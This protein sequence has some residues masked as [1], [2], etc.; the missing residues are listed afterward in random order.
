MYDHSSYMDGLGK[1]EIDQNS[2]LDMTDL[3]DKYLASFGLYSK[4]DL[5]EARYSRYSRF[6][7]VLDPYSRLNDT[8]EHLFF[9]KPDLHICATGTE[10]EDGYGGKE[11][12]SVN[13]LTLNPQ[14]DT[15][16]YFRDLI[17]RYPDVV[18]ELQN[19][20]GSNNK[21]PFSHLLSFT[22]NS[23]L[24]LPGSEAST[25]DTGNT[26]F[27]TNL[28]YLKDSEV[29]DENPSFSLEFI[30]TKKL[31]V[32]QYFKAY[33]MYH[34]ARKSGIVT[35]P[36]IDYIRY[37]R[38]HNVMGIFK[39][40]IDEDGETIVHYSYFWGVYPVS[41]PREA[42]SNQEFNEGLTFSI[43]FKAAFVE[44]SDPRILDHFNHLMM[45]LVQDPNKYIPIV[46]NS[47]TSNT[48]DI[49]KG[50]VEARTDGEGN[51][52]R[53][54]TRYDVGAGAMINGTLPKAALVDGRMKEGETFKKYR[55]RW[56]E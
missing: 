26:I 11:D 7:R 4:E 40:L 42:F 49:Q 27:G 9:V 52:A 50:V 12:Y 33:S 18:K 21:D 55:L 51:Y 2:R 39:F 54:A 17:T 24:D 56:Y 14:L 22:V 37:K 48:L 1:M 41:V 15:N 53:S 10:L 6:G 31:E 23:N 34:I 29:A 38:L 45:P 44:D 16:A 36:H 19:S 28:E 32:Y 13:G 46:D 5:A 30:D 20:A 43:S 35:P 25:I 3:K 47:F 8:R